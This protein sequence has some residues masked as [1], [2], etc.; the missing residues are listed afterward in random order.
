MF[1]VLIRD[2]IQARLSPTSGEPASKAIARLPR[3]LKSDPMAARTAMLQRL[4]AS[5]LFAYGDRAGVLSAAQR[6]SG[7]A[8]RLDVRQR[9]IVKALVS[10]HTGRGAVRGTA[11]PGRR[12][13]LV[14]G[15]RRGGR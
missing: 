15:A 14:P 4:A 2:A 7:R 3:R 13:G 8:F 5:R 11:A 12:A 9:V 10:R 6:R 1:A